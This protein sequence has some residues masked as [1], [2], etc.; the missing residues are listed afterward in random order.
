MGGEGRTGA[1][2]GQH[3]GRGPRNWHEFTLGDQVGQT[4]R[5][6]VV[7]ESF[8]SHC[9]SHHHVHTGAVVQ[10]G[11]P[12]CGGFAGVKTL[13]RPEGARCVLIGPQKSGGGDATRRGIRRGGKSTE[14][15]GVLCKGEH[16][17]SAGGE[18]REQSG[19]AP[20]RAGH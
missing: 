16:L 5:G 9:C 10:V 4:G 7:N 19:L 8:F 18:T 6:E 12:S 2:R 3:A 13:A 15:S 1:E 11:R 17:L 20:P 14:L